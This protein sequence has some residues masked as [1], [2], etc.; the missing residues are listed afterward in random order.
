MDFNNGKAIA[1]INAHAP[2]ILRDED[3]RWYISS[4]EWPYRGISLAPL[5]WD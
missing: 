2:E 1:E 5:E 4:A 3:G